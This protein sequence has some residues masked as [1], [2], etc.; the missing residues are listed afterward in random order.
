MTMTWLPEKTGALAPG[1]VDKAPATFSDDLDT[2]SGSGASTPV[3][4][5]KEKT[6]AMI[7]DAVFGE[8]D[9]ENNSGPN[10]RGVGAGG[11]FVLMTKA[12]LG[13]GVLAIPSVFNSLGIVPG[14]L[15]IL[16]IELM[17]CCE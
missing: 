10:F 8:I 5:P 17:L 9:L 7:H 1:A 15:I 12:N 16:G 14:I 13:L 11:A 4:K 6:N 2:S 3:P